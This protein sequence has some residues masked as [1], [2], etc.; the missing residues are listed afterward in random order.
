MPWDASD[1]LP[2]VC[3]G[4]W[5][6]LN[7]SRAVLVYNGGGKTGSCEHSQGNSVRADSNSQEGRPEFAQHATHGPGSKSKV[8]VL[9]HTAII[10]LL[11]A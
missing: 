6:L 5:R 3:E 4:L 8:G 11:M 1:F 10:F 9:L 2:L 7:I